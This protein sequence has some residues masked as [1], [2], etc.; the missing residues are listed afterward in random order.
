M[1]ILKT[2]ADLKKAIINCKNLG[3]VPTMGSLHKGHISLIKNS[4]KKS[5][6]TLVSIFINPTQFNN[7]TDYRTYP[8][9]I[10]QDIQIL[11]KLSTEHK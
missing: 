8:K 1:K 3:F 7:K 2:K 11:K 6:N 10:N 5:N 9:N 4:Q